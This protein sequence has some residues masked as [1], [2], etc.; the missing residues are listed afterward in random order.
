[1]IQFLRLQTANAGGEGSIPDQ[2]T[3]IPHAAWHNQKKKRIV[4]LKQP[5]LLLLF[6]V[7]FVIH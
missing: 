2:A 3:K 7:N 1:M 4:D 6:V 5:M